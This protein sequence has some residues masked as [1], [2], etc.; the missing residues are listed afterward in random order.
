MKRALFFLLLLSVGISQATA[1]ALV[2]YFPKERSETNS[3]Y[4]REINYFVE[5]I[6]GTEESRQA[7]TMY[8]LYF[9]S[10]QTERIDQQAAEAHFILGVSL[11]HPVQAVAAGLPI[12]AESRW[13][14]TLIDGRR[15]ITTTN[16]LFEESGWSIVPVLSKHILLALGTADEDLILISWNGLSGSVSVFYHPRFNSDRRFY[17]EKQKLFKEYAA[18]HDIRADILLSDVVDLVSRI[19]VGA[20]R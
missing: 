1:Q 20:R 10:K 8:C 4:V 16:A 14:A 5:T 19:T 7:E 11:V 6:S 12:Q 3:P 17:E 13:Y 18:T 9:G 15:N 2:T